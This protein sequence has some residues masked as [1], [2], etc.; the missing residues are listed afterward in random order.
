MSNSQ[1]TDITN[2]IIDTNTQT[3]SYIDEQYLNNIKIE[4]VILNPTPSLNEVYLWIPETSDNVVPGLD[5][6]ITYIRSTYATLTALQNA[7]TN[8]HNDIQTEINNLEIPNQGNLNVDKELYYNTTH[9]DYTFQRNNTI[10][11]I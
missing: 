4:T 1:Q 5:S 8:I 7:I 6:M 3:K 9:T 10:T 2:N 11:Q